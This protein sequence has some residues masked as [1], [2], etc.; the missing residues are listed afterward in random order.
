MDRKRLRELAG[1]KTPLDE[2]AVVT[3]IIQDDVDD[4]SAEQDREAASIKDIVNGFA[5][6]GITISDRKVFIHKGEVTV[7]LDPDV[8]SL[9]QISGLNRAGI[10][11][12]ITLEANYDGGIVISFKKHS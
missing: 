3:G 6:C 10:G 2:A 9:A 4:E 12:D 5:H 8:Y 11:S 1:I 7:T